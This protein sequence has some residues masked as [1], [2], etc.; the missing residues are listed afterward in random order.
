VLHHV[1]GDHDHVPPAVASF[2][3]LRPT[4]LFFVHGPLITNATKV[5]WKIFLGTRS[6]PIKKDLSHREAFLGEP[7]RP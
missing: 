2:T 6:S 1:H 4:G 3:I 7:R 5:A